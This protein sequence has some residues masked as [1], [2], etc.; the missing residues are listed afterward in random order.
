[1]VRPGVGLELHHLEGQAEIADDQ[2]MK[3]LGAGLVDADVVG[4]PSGA[5]RLALRRQLS[6]EV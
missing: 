4:G 2:V 5:E 3:V 6:D 1:M